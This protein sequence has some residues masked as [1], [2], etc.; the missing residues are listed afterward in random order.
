MTES[1]GFSCF[2]VIYDVAT[3]RAFCVFEAIVH[4]SQAAEIH[5]AH[6]TVVIH[7]RNGVNLCCGGLTDSDFVG[8]GVRHV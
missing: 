1:V 6:R 3:D 8:C 4:V 2:C 7:T 5:G